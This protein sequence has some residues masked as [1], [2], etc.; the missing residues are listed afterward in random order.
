MADICTAL[1]TVL[2]GAAGVTAIVD[3]R[4]YP[5]R[6]PQDVVYPCITYSLYRD[7]SEHHMGGLSGLAEAAIEYECWA[8]TRLASRA[9]Y[10]QVRLA[11]SRYKGV[12]NSVDVRQVIP[13]GGDSYDVAP[14]DGSDD[15]L[16]VS[17]RDFAAWYREA[18]S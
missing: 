15:A 13:L 10:E 1:R 2:T 9:L 11:L 3:N 18:T 12:A 7:T 14:V 16:Y 8:T 4:I 5:D 17:S 6:R